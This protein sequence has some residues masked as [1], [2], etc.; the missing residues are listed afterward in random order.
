MMVSGVVLVSFA[1][2]LAFTTASRKLQGDDVSVA[3]VFWQNWASTGLPLVSRGTGGSSVRLTKYVPVR[4]VPAGGGAATVKVTPLLCI[5]LTVITT[6]P[7]FVK[8][9]IALTALG[10]QLVTVPVTPL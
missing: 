8:G 5:P 4:S 7:V 1:S 2:P 9:A 6:F 10:F 3:L